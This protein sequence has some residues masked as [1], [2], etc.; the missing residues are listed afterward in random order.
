MS[1][2]KMAA[3]GLLKKLITAKIGCPCGCI[4]A[5]AVFLLMLP[6][7]FG[8]VMN[9]A[10]SW[11]W[12]GPDSSEEREAE[13]ER[14][15]EMYQDAAD[16]ANSGLPE[17]AEAWEL[18]WEILP[19]IDVLVTDNRALDEFIGGP[20][21]G[22]E[23]QA[24]VIHPIPGSDL[25]E[26][27]EA[28]NIN[29]HLPDVED[30]SDLG[31]GGYVKLE[32]D[33]TNE[34]MRD[35]PA[36]ARNRLGETRYSGLWNEEHEGLYWYFMWT[37]KEM[38]D[39]YH[40]NF[41]A[42]QI[43]AI[44]EA[45]ELVD[46]EGVELSESDEDLRIVT[47]YLYR[48]EH[49]HDL[50]RL[51]EDLAPELIEDETYTNTTHEYSRIRPKAS[52]D[53]H[54]HVN[55]LPTNIQVPS[56][57]KGGAE[58]GDTWS[59]RNPWTEKTYSATYVECEEEGSGWEGDSFPSTF[60]V[61]D[62]AGPESTYTV[63]ARRS[64]ASNN[65][66]N[67]CIY[68]LPLGWDLGDID[69]CQD[70]L[71]GL[72]DEGI[73]SKNTEEESVDKVREIE[74]YY[75]TYELDYELREDPLRVSHN[76][77]M[78][79]LEKSCGTHIVRNIQQPNIHRISDSDMDEDWS[80]FERATNRYYFGCDGDDW[81]DETTRIRFADDDHADDREMIV[82]FSQNI[83]IN[84]YLMDDMEGGSFDGGYSGGMAGGT[85]N[86]Q[87]YMWP[88]PVVDPDGSYSSGF[89]WRRGQWHCG[90]DIP[91]THNVNPPVVA[92]RDA[93]IIDSG[94]CT[95]RGYYVLMM[96]KDSGLYYQYMHLHQIAPGAKIGTIS[97]GEE[98]GLLGNTGGSDGDH[99]HFEVYSPICEETK[100]GVFNELGISNP[101][102]GVDASPEHC[103]H[104]VDRPDYIRH[105]RGLY[106]YNAMYFIGGSR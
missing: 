79:E 78:C 75:G 97:Q 4:A 69:N 24:D 2:G 9:E 68:S 27:A 15:R 12:G 88:V 3:S 71:E 56:I 6:G 51:A 72:V 34:G 17:H 59:V 83:R 36:G 58:D 39:H 37:C 96:G 82:Q 73:F 28:L 5:I 91:Y 103:R 81:K 62:N 54:F 89:G 85:P 1:V 98:V 101:E 60:T 94:Y 18:Q 87:G 7:L 66:I 106:Y 16:G 80:R 50:P 23:T 21:G 76:T 10:V 20:T 48:G 30:N 61:S 93:E 55:E 70:Q 99:L 57:N 22:V 35:T 64:W 33:E 26:A 44:K 52:S 42:D 32:I 29:Q 74:T 47:L 67:V 105:D 11:L 63:T 95:S 49:H 31:G 100:D 92:V 13:Y 38:R 77:G 53:K 90:V 43:E 14:R 45:G 102:R 65:S 40:D 46:P 104:N 8:S 19:A 41:D 25:F 86:L 84:D